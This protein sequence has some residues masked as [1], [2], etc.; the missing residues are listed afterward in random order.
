MH[1]C[2]GT[3]PARGEIL[4]E[5]TE[6][7]LALSREIVSFLE[8]MRGTVYLVKPWKFE[9]SVLISR[10]GGVMLHRKLRMIARLEPP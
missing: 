1:A 10:F 6:S 5:V 4:G 9:G 7:C 2:S 8:G 3:G